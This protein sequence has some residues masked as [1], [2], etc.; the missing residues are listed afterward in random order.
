[1]E[2][3]QTIDF[4]FSDERRFADGGAM[5]PAIIQELDAVSMLVLVTPLQGEPFSERIYFPDE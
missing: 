4:T 2:V 3:G 5:S 1:M